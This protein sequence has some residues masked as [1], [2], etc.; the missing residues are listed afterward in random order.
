MSKPQNNRIELTVLRAAAHTARWT[1]QEA[2]WKD[3]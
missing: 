2:A 3:A 1:D